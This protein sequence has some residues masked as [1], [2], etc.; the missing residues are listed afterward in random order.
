MNSRRIDLISVIVPVYN[1]ENYL[2]EA[3]Q[4]IV[5]Q[6]HINFECIVVDDGSTNSRYVQN[7]VNLLDDE[8]FRFFRQENA[9]V[10][11]ALNK[12]FSESRGNYITWLSHDDL[13]MAGKLKLQLRLAKENTILFSNYNLINE[14][15]DLIA[16]TRFEK[17]FDTHNELTLLTRGLIHGCTAFIPREVFIKIG[18]FNETLLYTQ[19]YDFWLRAIENEITFE[20]IHEITT[21]GR[22]HSSQTGKVSDIRPENIAI[23]QRIIDYWFY[24][25]IDRNAN[26]RDLLVKINEFRS[27]AISSK[28]YYVLEH[29]DLKELEILSGENDGFAKMAQALNLKYNNKMGKI[30]HRRIMFYFHEALIRLLIFFWRM[31]GR[32]NFIRNNSYLRGLFFR[33]SRF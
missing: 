4:S 12:G 2:Q 23:W 22:V 30:K 19:D 5:S 26:K 16:A 11:S 10:A 9:G 17:Q 8:R 6:T 27:W 15:G 14:T 3:L 25:E 31:T 1:G 13:W 7:V 32:P 24:V 20:F 28:I 33:I 18:L 29:L 21:T